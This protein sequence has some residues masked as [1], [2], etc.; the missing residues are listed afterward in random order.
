VERSEVVLPQ[1]PAGQKEGQGEGGEGHHDRRDN[2]CQQH[3]RLVRLVN[4]LAS[5]SVR[6]LVSIHVPAIL[7]A[8]S[9]LAHHL[10]AMR[11]SVLTY[12]GA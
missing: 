12:L 1:R 4:P 10:D 6:V 3:G 7:L 11:V 5:V 9:D 8:R 2:Q